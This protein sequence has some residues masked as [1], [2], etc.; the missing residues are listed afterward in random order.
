MATASKWQSQ[1]SKPSMPASGA[2]SYAK[3]T[4]YIE[5]VKIGDQMPPV[6]QALFLVLKTEQ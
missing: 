5:L 1:E 2:D 3:N 4:K 6:P